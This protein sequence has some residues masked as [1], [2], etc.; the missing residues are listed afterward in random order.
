MITPIQ[1][2]DHL[3]KSQ[4]PRG[5][6]RAKRDEILMTKKAEGGSQDDCRE[7]FSLKK[8]RLEMEQDWETIWSSM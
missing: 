4:K 7:R 1:K 8:R 5:Q 6:L 2:E 3:T